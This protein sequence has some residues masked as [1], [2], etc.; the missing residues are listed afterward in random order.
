MIDILGKPVIFKNRT[1]YILRWRTDGIKAFIDYFNEKDYNKYI[2]FGTLPA[3]SIK[4]KTYR[5]RA[6]RYH[7]VMP[8]LKYA[9][10]TTE[11]LRKLAGK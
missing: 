8:K 11:E 10:L 3:S 9:A 7:M 1:I 6:E 5:S 4:D 2:S